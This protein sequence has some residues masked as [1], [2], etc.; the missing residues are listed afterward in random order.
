MSTATKSPDSPV[1]L[2]TTRVNQY[3]ATEVI[4]PALPKTFVRVQCGGK[5]HE[6]Y[7]E[8]DGVTMPSITGKSYK[9]PT[10]V[11]KAARTW[12][13]AQAVTHAENEASH[14][15]YLASGGNILPPRGTTPWM[16][17][18]KDAWDAGV[19]TV[20]IAVKLDL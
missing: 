13:D 15:A 1:T 4:H 9:S 14:A 3:G 17:A 16:D 5:G 8:S 6:L 19:D 18:V 12:L 11:F 20:A 7:A 10:A 2:T